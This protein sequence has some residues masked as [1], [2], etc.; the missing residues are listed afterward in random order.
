MG[1]ATAIKKHI[2]DATV[3]YSDVVREVSNI[4][5]NLSGIQLGERQSPMVENRLKTR[6]LRLG[7]QT[8]QEYLKYLKEHL[9]S[10]SQSL[11]SLLT[12]HHTYF[13]REF[14]HFEYLQFK[15]LPVL[16]DRA[17]QRGDKKIQVWSAACSRGQ[18]V[19]S[20]AMFLKFHLANTAPD[21]SFE[22]FGSDVDP[23]SVKFAR[24]GVY[25]HNE[26]KEVP[27]NYL[28]SHWVRG[29][30]EISDYV[31]VKESLKDHCK[32]D[33]INLLQIGNKFNGKKFDF[34]WCRNVFIYFNQDQII[35]CT[36]SIMSQMHDHGFFFVG[37][38]ETL[39]GLPLDIQS[40]GP[41]VYTRKNIAVAKPVETVKST[42]I[43]AMSSPSAR[44]SAPAPSISLT[45][46]YDPN[47]IVKV[48]CVDDSPS[49]VTL[50]KR[51]LS[52]E[53]GFEIV[54]VAGNGIEA[55]D[56]LKKHKVDLVT[57]DIHMP[58]MDGLTY[59]QKHFGPSHP[60]VVMISSVNRDNADIA[61]KAL[62]LGASD[63]IEKPSLANL[64]T[65]GDE[66]RAK[67]KS[68]YYNKSKPGQISIVDKSFKKSLTIPEP[69]NKRRVC[70]AGL[71]DRKSIVRI[72]SDLETQHPPQFFFF[73]GVGEALTP[74]A[75]ALI[76]ETR[77]N[78]Q[79]V[80]QIPAQPQVGAIYFADV[81]LLTQ[82]QQ[83]SVG[84]KTSMMV[85]G[86]PSQSTIQEVVKWSDTH[87][88]LEDLGPQAKNKELSEICN[89]SIPV[90]SYVSISSEFF[91]G[92]K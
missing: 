9:E 68:T 21:V 77:K 10:E 38:S 20:L 18:E 81:K 65:R 64:T 59:L 34:V 33:P 48:L 44:P 49:I 54:A 19:Y 7:I 15:V 3:N 67:L 45:P 78:I 8:P 56:Q 16:I 11:L 47:Y 28:G 23:E 6:M 88:L 36:Q 14:S 35:H 84:H 43:P 22:I 46:Q 39:T 62:E 66:I 52:K 74:F 4:V 25:H 53:N 76:S 69:Q 91:G 60:P 12:T 2:G 31:K 86:M 13:F 26:I 42:A 71:S 61:V 63:Y 24:N 41:S 82:L 5:S 51:I 70:V 75:K 87:L 37:I 79:L 50:L 73:E 85:L 32:F 29:K 55:A 83:Y 90:T 92:L 27:V 80:D 57:L 1:H 17:R 40:V 30:G 58:E 72:I 89:D